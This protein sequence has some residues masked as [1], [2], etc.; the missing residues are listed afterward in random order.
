MNPRP[1]TEAVRKFHTTFVRNDNLEMFDRY[2]RDI[3]SREAEAVKRLKA[4]GNLLDIGCATGVFLENFGEVNWRLFG[5][6][7]TSLGANIVRAKQ[8]AEVFNGTVAEAQY[9]GGF[10]D[11]VSILD[12]LYYDPDPRAT[13]IEIRRVLKDDG[14]LAVEVPGF[15]HTL[16][17]N[18][19]PLCWLLDRRWTKGFIGSYHL[20]YFSPRSLRLLLEAAGFRVLK[21][22]PEQASLNRRGLLRALNELHFFLVRLLF[23]VSGGRSSVAGKELYLAVKSGP[24]APGQALGSSA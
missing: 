12:T 5:V 24:A 10:F 7:T 22:I 18:S 19:G 23:K 16:L 4:G 3:L 15:V 1:T 20:Y 13:L 17:R 8:R 6:D 14:L 21:M 2:R 9:P 11:V